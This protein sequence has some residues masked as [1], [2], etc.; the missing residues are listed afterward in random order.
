VST[1]SVVLP[2]GTAPVVHDD[3]ALPGSVAA[4]ILRHDGAVASVISVCGPIERFRDEV[5]ACTGHLL[6]VTGALSAK[7]GHR[8]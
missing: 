5:E 3:T 2:C 4:P 8:A 1:I 6:E 7:L